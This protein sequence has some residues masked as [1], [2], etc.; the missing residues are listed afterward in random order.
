MH[1]LK[2]A[3]AGKKSVE[4]DGVERVD[5]WMSNVLLFIDKFVNF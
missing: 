5:A 3:C 4:C 1:P 2:R